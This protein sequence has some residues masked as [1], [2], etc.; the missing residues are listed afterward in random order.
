MEGSI[1][2]SAAVAAELE[3]KFVEARLHTDLGGYAKRAQGLR[4]E[5]TNSIALPIY[6]VIDPVTGKVGG[7]LQGGTSAGRFA[8]FL[9]ES[10]KSLGI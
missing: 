6:V 4:A 8:K 2:P 10:R 3:S 9:E 7:E 1:F 5:L